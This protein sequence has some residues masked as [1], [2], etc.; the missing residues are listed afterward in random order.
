M[1]IVT[2]SWF[3][4]C[5]AGWAFLESINVKIQASKKFYVALLKDQFLNP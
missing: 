1:D 2:A 3:Q 4:S 5:L